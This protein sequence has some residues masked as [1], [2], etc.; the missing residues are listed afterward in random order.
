MTEDQAERLI[1]L[2]ERIAWELSRRRHR[3]ARHVDYGW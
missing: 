1:A 2:L 3:A